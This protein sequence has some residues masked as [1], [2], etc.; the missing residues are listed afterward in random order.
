[1]IYFHLAGVNSQTA[2]KKYK[3][4]AALQRF[5]KE[6]QRLLEILY[7]HHAYSDF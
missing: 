2:F 5:R 1:M 4:M 7:L 6:I 3:Q